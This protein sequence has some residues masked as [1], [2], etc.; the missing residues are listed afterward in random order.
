[1]E[2]LLDLIAIGDTK[3]I[4]EL[5]ALGRDVNSQTEEGLTLLMEAANVGDLEIVELLV[6]NGAEVNRVDVHGNSALIYASR[7]HHWKIFEYLSLLT[8]TSLKEASLFM[9]IYNNEAE[10]I[11][12][13]LR[14]EKSISNCRQKGIWS[15]NGLTAL[16]VA[17]QEGSSS[18]VQKLLRFDANPD[19]VDEDTCKTAL[20]YAIEYEKLELVQLLVEAGADLDFR[21]G[22][23]E[24]PLLKAIKLGNS[25]IIDFLT[26]AN[27]NLSVESTTDR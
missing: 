6:K 1:M 27:T 15:E 25:E 20:V 3:R 21:D 2:D 12:I 18:I 22:S 10:A 17:V 9:A 24:T 14:S 5:I 16:M 8:E 19:L 23:S 11:D 4:G 26:Q 7:E 13:L